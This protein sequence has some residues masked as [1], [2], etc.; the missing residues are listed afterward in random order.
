MTRPTDGRRVE[1]WLDEKATWGFSEWHSDVYYQ[2]DIQ[3]LTLLTEHAE[4]TSPAGGGHAR[5]V[6]LRPRVHQVSGNNGVTHGRSYMKD[7]SRA[8]DQDVFGSAKL[9]FGT[10]D[11]P[12]SVPD[13]HGRCSWPPPRATGCRS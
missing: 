11:V 7:K 12:V 8:T 4:P 2:E 13:G 3:A 5:P 9:L 6:P 1:A 10:S